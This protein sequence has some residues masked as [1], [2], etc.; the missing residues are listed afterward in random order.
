M[1][2]SRTKDSGNSLGVGREIQGAHHPVRLSVLLLDINW[3]WF[4]SA[5]CTFKR[6]P[7]YFHGVC[8]DL[9]HRCGRSDD[10]EDVRKDQRDDRWKVTIISSQVGTQGLSWSRNWYKKKTLQQVSVLMNISESANMSDEETR[11]ELRKFQIV[12]LNENCSY[13]VSNC[14][15]IPRGGTDKGQWKFG[16]CD[17]H[18][19]AQGRRVSVFYSN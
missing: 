17:F 9:C 3:P 12:V 4:F 2:A 13:V 10:A 8:G 19:P 5:W 15:N 1:I 18:S 7:T 16:F 6:W 14:K 11:P